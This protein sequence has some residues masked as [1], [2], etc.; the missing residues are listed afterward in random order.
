MG[1]LTSGKIQALL[2]PSLPVR[3]FRAG[4]WVSRCLVSEV[5]MPMIFERLP[6]LLHEGEVPFGGGLFGPSLLS[7]RMGYSRQTAA[8]II[9][10]IRIRRTL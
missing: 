4:A 7:G 9:P 3:H 5:A 2:L 1:F 6:N 10:E 8:A